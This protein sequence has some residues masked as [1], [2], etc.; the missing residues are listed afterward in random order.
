MSGGGMVPQ[1]FDTHSCTVKRDK[2]VAPALRSESTKGA[3]KYWP[4][5]F[6]PVLIR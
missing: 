3:A 1:R 2:I 6:P 5:G 4:T